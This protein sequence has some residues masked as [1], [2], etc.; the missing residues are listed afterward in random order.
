MIKVNQN[1]LLLT[2]G[3]NAYQVYLQALYNGLKDIIDE[4][5]PTVEELKNYQ[6]GDLIMEITS[7]RRAKDLSRNIGIFLL[8]REENCLGYDKNDDNAP[9]EMVYYMEK[10]NG[11]LMSWTNCDFI[12]IIESTHID[13]KE[14]YARLKEKY[15]DEIILP[16]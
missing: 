6:P 13:K 1:E 12:K 15:G 11:E 7:W 16:E 8:Q 9:K 10:L 2:L 5:Q 3:H 4:K 14:R